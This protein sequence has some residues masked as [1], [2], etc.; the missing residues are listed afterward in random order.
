MRIILIF[1]KLQFKLTRGVITGWGGS[2]AGTWRL[3]WAWVWVWSC[4]T[5][6]PR[7]SSIRDGERLD[8]D[9]DNK[10]NIN[11]E[12]NRL[13]NPGKRNLFSL[14]K[15]LLYMIPDKSPHTLATIEDGY[16]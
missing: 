7:R 9:V 12:A 3:A 5:S 11:L 1:L 4:R 10:G 16:W 8:D 15:P 13:R 14:K 2:C 6:C